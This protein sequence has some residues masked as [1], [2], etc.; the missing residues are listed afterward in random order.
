MRITAA[1]DPVTRIEGHLNI[2]ITI[3]TVNGLQ[4]V[5]DAKAVGGLFRGF[6][7][8]LIGRDPRDAQHITERICG[9]CPVAHGL[10]AVRALDSAFGV[11]VPPNGRI[12]RNLTN[13]SNFV[14]SHVLHFYL[15][16]LPDY[17]K[18]PVAAPWQADW[19]ID[20]RFSS[21][22]SDR[23]MQ[24]YLQALTMRRKADQMTAVFGGRMPHPPAFVPGGFTANPRP[25]RIA[26]FTAILDELTAFIE[27][28]YIP[29]VEF[30]ASVYDDYRSWGRGPGNLLAYG[31]FELDDAQTRR[32]FARGIAWRGTDAVEALDANA[33]HEHVLHS[34]F[35]NHAPATP[36]ESR[37]EPQHPKNGAYTWLK[38]PRYLDEPCEV[39]PLARMWVNG[40][41][42]QGISTMDRHLARAHEALK[43]ARAMKQ[44]VAELTPEGPVC[45]VSVPV[46]AAGAAGL[47]EAPRGG[48][49]HW[50]R[51]EQGRIAHYQ[52]ISPT[53][54]NVSPRDDAG[55]PGPLEQALLGVPIENAEQ[56]IEIMRIIHSFDPCLDCATHLMRPGKQAKIYYVR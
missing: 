44:W 14:E 29:D 27:N 38:A 3:D 28:T 8:L 25:D 53:T 4:Q 16:S 26:T 24:H 20:R 22:D 19:D 56:P 42:R 35:R 1:F 48:L 39:G 54:W 33:I 37:T 43:I 15:L 5:V 9:V 31:A 6:E 2:E 23:L 52:V 7:K 10:A 51:I 30:L 32:L 18:G 17:I 41:Y 40:D 50:V 34:W 47:T 21:A 13:G 49:G 46:D 45:N 11:P 36:E 12:L 55:V